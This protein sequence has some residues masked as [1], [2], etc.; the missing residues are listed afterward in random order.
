MCKIFSGHII[1]DENSKDWGNVIY[2]SGIH[3][4]L[5]REEIYKKYGKDIKLTAWESK[6]EFSTK[7]FIITHSTEIVYM[8]AKKLNKLIRAFNKHIRGEI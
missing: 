8:F 7:D 4:E 6:D 2:L 1:T 3:H 5:D